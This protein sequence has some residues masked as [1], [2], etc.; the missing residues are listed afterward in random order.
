MWK[1]VIY[2]FAL[3]LFLAL[4]MTVYM[5]GCRDLFNLFCM[6]T[7]KNVT[8]PTCNFQNQRTNV[9]QSSSDDDDCQ[10][11]DVMEPSRAPVAMHSKDADTLDP[12]LR[13]FGVRLVT[14][15][16]QPL[17]IKDDLDADGPDGSMDVTSTTPG[18]RPP[19]S[20]K[21]ILSHDIHGTVLQRLVS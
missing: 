10:I 18:R 16:R 4:L 7:Q 20:K 19:A 14:D 3:K 8:I 13:A 6:S 5:L 1:F 11:V 21:N 12:A 2:R 9:I 17:P 15:F